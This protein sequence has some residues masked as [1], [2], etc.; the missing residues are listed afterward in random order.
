MTPLLIAL[1]LAAA[2][3][4]PEAKPQAIAKAQSSSESSIRA[5]GEWGQRMVAAQ[6]PAIDAFH[7]CTPIV[8]QMVAAT[9]ASEAGGDQDIAGIMPGVRACLTEAKAASLASQ[10]RLAALPPMPPAAERA[11][12]IDTRDLLRRGAAAM[13]EMAT[14]LDLL[15]QAFDAALAGNTELAHRKWRES[16]RSAAGALDAQI[17]ILEAVRASLPLETHK[18]MADIR[19]NINRAVRLITVA[20]LGDEGAPSELREFGA[21]Q[22]LAVSRM[23]AH[24]QRE[25]STVRRSLASLDANIRTTLLNAADTAMLQVMEAGEASVTVLE[26]AQDGGGEAQLIEISDRLAAIEVQILGTIRAMSTSMAQ[27]N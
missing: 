4:S 18:A 3:G 14:G 13:G 27:V 7:R 23:R 5:M 26:S 21:A 24:W 2:S 19:L 1:A 6:Q 25:L 15:E 20:E 22:R 17:L 10:E 16:T 11:L 8:Q 12:G 9:R